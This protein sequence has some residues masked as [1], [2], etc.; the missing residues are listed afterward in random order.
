MPI[1][2]WPRPFR[3][4]QEVRFSTPL[5]RPPSGVSDEVS[6]TAPGVRPKTAL[7]SLRTSTPETSAFFAAFRHAQN[8]KGSVKTCLF[9][10]PG[11]SDRFPP[12]IQYITGTTPKCQSFFRRFRRFFPD[13]FVKIS[14]NFRSLN[15]TVGAAVSRPCRFDL[16][17]GGCCP[18]LLGLR[19]FCAPRL[20]ARR[21]GFQ[22][23][24]KKNAVGRCR[25]ACGAA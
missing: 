22:S 18:P 24:T 19:R 25:A 6:A 17:T 11:R 14:R 7:C 5:F 21:S 13:F 2:D 3:A 4:L 10:C 20:K 23:E 16:I 1:P 12:N 9:I 8:S 15:P